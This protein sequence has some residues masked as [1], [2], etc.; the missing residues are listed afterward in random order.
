MQSFI[1]FIADVSVPYNPD[2]LVDPNKMFRSLSTEGKVFFLMQ[3]AIALNYLDRVYDKGLPT[4]IKEYK[5]KVTKWWLLDLEDE[6]NNLDSGDGTLEKEGYLNILALLNA[7]QSNQIDAERCSDWAANQREDAPVAVKNT[8]YSPYLHF[9]ER[10][11]RSETLADGE[12]AQNT[13]SFSVSNLV[14]IPTFSYR[15]TL[16]SVNHELSYPGYKYDYK[17]NHKYGTSPY[18][19]GVESIF[20]YWRGYNWSDYN[21]NSVVGVLAAQC[22]DLDTNTFPNNS[23]LWAYYDIYCKV[24]GWTP[25]GASESNF[26]WLSSESNFLRRC[27]LSF[28][29]DLRERFKIQFDDSE[30]LALLVKGDNAEDADQLHA[31]LQASQ[32]TEVSVEMYNAFQKSPFARF[33]EL[34]LIKHNRLS[35]RELM[36]A[37]IDARNSETDPSDTQQDDDSTS[38]RSRRNRS[39]RPSGE[40]RLSDSS[41]DQLDEE[42]GMTEDPAQPDGEDEEATEG[43]EPNTGRLSDSSFDELDQSTEPEADATTPDEEPTDPEGTP[44]GTED[45]THNT[46]HTQVPDMPN[47]DDKK[48]VKLELSTGETVNSVLYRIELEAYID[49][50]LSTNSPNILSAQKIEF[51]KRIKA[52]WIN[53]LSPE[54]LVNLL[55]SIVKLPK[56]LNINKNKD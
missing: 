4:L 26:I 7:D 15:G 6:V 38:G 16:L 5:E 8:F 46:Q 20:S 30:L 27:V 36:E 45:T 52:Y 34:D 1:K 43:G 17:S 2:W 21:F 12:F 39:G 47:M 32:P 19:M 37:S 11:R 28:L 9:A 22:L 10:A 50:L 54:S 35:S 51:L 53:R 25:K 40:P 18:G 24:S 14:T 31:F 23:L 3:Q 56:H 13:E 48:G 49:S 29:I 42:T 44:E 33:D 55:N 41:F